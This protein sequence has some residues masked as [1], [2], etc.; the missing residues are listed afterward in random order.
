[1]SEDASFEDGA[2]KALRLKA[3]DSE[4]LAIVTALLQDAVLPANEMR[5]QKS[6]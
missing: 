2:E 6:R 1:M 4:D 3:E 5:W